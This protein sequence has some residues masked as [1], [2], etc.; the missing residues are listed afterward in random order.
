MLRL[1]RLGDESHS[2]SSTDTLP[3]PRE[4]MWSQC[5]GTALGSP[6]ASL[7]TM[8]AALRECQSA[9]VPLIYFRKEKVTPGEQR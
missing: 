4:P 8:K 5:L 1:P 9:L 2:Y 7:T 6:A 3:A